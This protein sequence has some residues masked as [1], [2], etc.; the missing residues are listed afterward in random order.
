MASPVIA[1]WLMPA[2]PLKAA[3]SGASAGLEYRQQNLQDEQHAAALA[4]AAQEAQMAH[5]IEQ[6]KVTGTLA[7]ARARRD[8]E[9]QQ[10]AQKFQAIRGYQAD[11]E[12]GADA[13][14]AALKWFPAI[15]NGDTSGLS[16][17]A[18]DQFMGKQMAQVPKAFMDPDGSV[19]GYQLGDRMILK[20][21]PR[22]GRGTVPIGLKA[23]LDAAV[24]LM[25]ADP[26]PR[27]VAANQQKVD[28]L[29][30]EIDNAMAGGDSEEVQSP[31]NPSAGAP[32]YDF[33]Y[34][35]KTGK[36]TPVGQ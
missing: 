13:S 20:P 22:P 25:T 32:A 17:L 7:E 10:A 15:N 24:K 14:S 4:Q 1:P 28:E 36:F 8:I 34:D 3:Q 29:A 5:Q 16:S 27:H 26:D 23:R 35:A 21:T 2:D 18:R 31:M 12:G 11:L 19:A 9:A 30:K 33:E 6:E